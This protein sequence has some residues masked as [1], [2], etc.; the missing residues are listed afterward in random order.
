MRQKDKWT[1]RQWEVEKE[2]EREK[3]SDTQRAPE[4]ERAYHQA[5]EKKR[6]VQQAK[7]DRQ[8]EG[9]VDMQRTEIE[10]NSQRGIEREGHIQ[11]TE[12]NKQ[13][14]RHGQTEGDTYRDKMERGWEHR[15]KRPKT[16][17]QTNRVTDQRHEQRGRL[18]RRGRGKDT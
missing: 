17:S 2:E 7:R 5:K 16:E 15:E 11:K 4:T 12:C 13:R 6:K 10:T 18:R 1:D 8:M 9:Q 3:D 14:D